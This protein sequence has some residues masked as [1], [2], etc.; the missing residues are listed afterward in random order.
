ME[1]ERKGRKGRQP[2]QG[3]AQ[4]VVM[5][6]AECFQEAEREKTQNTEEGQGEGRKVL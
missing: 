6:T 5:K 1:M 3:R 4:Q 2:C